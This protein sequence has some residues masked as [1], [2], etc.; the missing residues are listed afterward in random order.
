MSGAAKAAEPPR[1]KIEAWPTAIPAALLKLP[2]EAVVSSERSFGTHLLCTR[3]PAKD[4]RADIASIIDRQAEGFFTLHEAAQVLADGRPDLNLKP[5]VLAQEMLVAHAEGR[6]RIHGAD[7]RKPLQ[8]GDKRPRASLDLVRRDE[9]D[10]WLKGEGRGYQFPA[11]H[12]DETP[13]ERRAR[14]LAE[15]EE[16][17]K[18]NPRGALKL[19]Y[20]REKRTRPTADRSNIGKEIRKARAER[21]QERRDGAGNTWHPRA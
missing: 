9:I 2:D 21:A 16:A 8:S 13:K 1:F 6:L 19:V 18:V 12:R 3:E 10:A 20:E 4:L 5:G 15:F 11:V 17:E 7:T 14:W